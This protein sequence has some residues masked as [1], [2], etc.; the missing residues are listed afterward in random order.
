MSKFHAHNVFAPRVENQIYFQ[1][2]DLRSKIFVSITDFGLIEETP[3]N[4][5][6][7]NRPFKHGVFE[8]YGD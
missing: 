8:K 2:Y 7:T 5:K 4:W 6:S 3:T 1:V